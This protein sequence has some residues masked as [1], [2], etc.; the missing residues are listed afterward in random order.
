MP[1][2]LPRAA[3]PGPP[4]AVTTGPRH[5][6]VAPARHSVRGREE[7][8]RERGEERIGEEAKVFLVMREKRKRRREYVRRRWRYFFHV[9]HLR[10]PH[11]KIYFFSYGPLGGLHEKI[12]LFLH[13]AP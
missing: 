13:V 5:A 9:V 10:G 4:P 3:S 11:V 7:K 2:P 12:D 1:G 6:R 8:R